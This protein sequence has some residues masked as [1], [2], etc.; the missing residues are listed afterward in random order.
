MLVKDLGPPVGDG[1]MVT[2]AFMCM[3]SLLFLRH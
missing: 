3:T 1:D 2:D